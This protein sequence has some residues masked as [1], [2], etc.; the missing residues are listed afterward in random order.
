MADNP[1]MEDDVVELS[2][3]LHL[4]RLAQPALVASP[5]RYLLCTSCGRSFTTLVRSNCIT[6]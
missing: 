5:L 4:L 6:L 1:L 3:Y 2:G